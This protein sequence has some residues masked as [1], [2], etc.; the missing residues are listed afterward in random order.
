[1][2][3][4]PLDLYDASDI[5]SV[6]NTFTV[7]SH[8]SGNSLLSS[9][10]ILDF[11]IEETYDDEENIPITV[12]DLP[13]VRYSTPT[14]ILTILKLLRNDNQINFKSENNSND[15]N[16]IIN[17][18]DTV[19][20]DTRLR[21]FC[22]KRDIDQRSQEEVVQWYTT[23]WPNALLNTLPKIITKIPTLKTT[24]TKDKLLNYYTSIIQFF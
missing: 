22:L 2:M 24:E 9:N 15:N 12:L 16:R 11:N 8:A 14:I 20:L 1:M 17:C 3:F 4:D 18:D 5:R 6:E 7:E 23:Q 10:D 21:Q 19:V 13:P